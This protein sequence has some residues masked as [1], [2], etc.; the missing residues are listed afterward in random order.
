MSIVSQNSWK[1]KIFLSLGAFAA[2]AAATVFFMLLIAPSMMIHEQRSPYD[3]AKTVAMIQQKALEQGWKVSHVYDFARSLALEG[4]ES[5]RPIQVVELCQ[6]DYARGLLAKDGSRF[7]SVMMPCALA[8]YEKGDGFTYV[9]SMNVGFM[10]RLFGGDIAKTMAR[11][12]R[13]DEA[14]LSFLE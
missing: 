11:V 2:G 4:K 13:D 6:L 3:V 9:A 14:I 1:Q 5:I 7:V 12:A 8:V 10:G